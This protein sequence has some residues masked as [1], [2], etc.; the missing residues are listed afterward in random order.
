M[1]FNIYIK[2]LNYKM[3]KLYFRYGVM[4]SSKTANLL[5]VCHNYQ[6]QKKE[7][8][9]IKPQIDTRHENNIIKSR[10]GIE[11]NAE[12]LIDKDHDLF[13]NSIDYEK[14]NAILVDEAQFLTKE[15]VDQ[16]RILTVYLPIICYGLRTDYKSN[17][18]EGSKRLMEIADSIEEIKTTCFFCNKKATI[19]MKYS[20]NKIIREGTNEIDIGSEEKYLG[21]CWDCW[22]YKTEITS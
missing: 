2:I 10:C 6:I 15:Q 12:L 4:N 17:L 14:Y 19:N 16:L 8:L 13:K 5:M 18:F 22:F 7:V 20:N 11:K 21:T 1:I 3:P 9:L